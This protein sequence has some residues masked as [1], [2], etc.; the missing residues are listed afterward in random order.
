MRLHLIEHDPDYFNETNIT[1][2]AKKKGYH[3][4]KTEVFNQ[5]RLPQL[6]DF[7]WLMIM[8][9]SQHIWQEEANPW[10]I[11]EKK[12]IREAL[13]TGKN[14]LGVCL[15]AQLVAES[16]GSE[17]FTNIHEEIGWHEVSV[18]R[19]GKDTFLFRDIPDRFMTFH[20]H[21]DH[22]S[23]P[24]GCT[25]LASSEPTQNQA[26]IH[27]SYPVVGLQFHPEYTRAIVE[28]YADQYG[29]EW[30]PAPFVTGKE[31]VLVRTKQIP[32]TYWLMEILL[33]NM[34]RQFS[35]V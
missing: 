21:S 14:I 7:D 35:A 17:V 10:I 30:V 15:G 23:L 12:F 1:L 33:N 2:W 32:D 26:F 27:E 20:W 11:G 16:L 28:S 25:R 3:V 4:T 9:G 31:D 18:S 5:Q 22:F 6:D 19:E 13:T 24:S 34:D 8:G 29:H